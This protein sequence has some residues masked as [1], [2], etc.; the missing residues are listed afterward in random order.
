MAN[1]PVDTLSCFQ[2]RQ[3]PNDSHDLASEGNIHDRGKWRRCS[4][5]GQNLGVPNV[6]LDGVVGIM[7][8]LAVVDSLLD[9]WICSELLVAEIINRFSDDFFRLA[10]IC[11]RVF[12]ARIVVHLF[13]ISQCDLL[14]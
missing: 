12:V 5:C 11:S 14:P 9:S 13:V 10:L 3:A 2:H 8:W 1:L 7:L 6:H 4:G